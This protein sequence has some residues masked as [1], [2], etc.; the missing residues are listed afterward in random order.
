MWTSSSK[1]LERIV[2]HVRHIF[3]K[4]SRPE[5]DDDHRR[6]FAVVTYLETR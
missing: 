5:I 3:A 4:L 2:K 1:T 6:V